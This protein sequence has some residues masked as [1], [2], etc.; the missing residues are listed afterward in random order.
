MICQPLFQRHNDPDHYAV[1]IG[2]VASVE[3]DQ[4]VDIARPY[5]SSFSES[6]KIVVGKFAQGL[7]G[8]HPQPKGQ[9][10]AVLAFFDGFG[11]KKILEGLLEE[12]SQ[13]EAP[14]FVGGWE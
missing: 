13:F 6:G 5:V 14:N 8:L 2:V 10:K 3:F 9:A 12:P 4:S 7:I 1:I 11:R